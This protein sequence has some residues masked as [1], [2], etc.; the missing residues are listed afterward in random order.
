MAYSTL[1]G[2]AKGLLGT[3]APK[4]IFPNLDLKYI[5]PVNGHDMNAMEEALKQAKKYA[6]PVIVHAIT[7]K[8]KGYEPAVSDEADQFHAVGQIDPDT[9]KSVG[10]SGKQSWTGVFADE[11]VEIANKKSNVIGITAAMLI[12]VGLHKFAKQFP[13][14]KS[15]EDRAKATGVPLR[16]I[17]SCYNRGMAAWRTGHRPGATQQQ[18]GYARAASFAMCGKTHY[19]TDSDLVRSAKSSSASARKWF[20]R[21][22]PSKT[23]A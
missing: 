22:A 23:T 12:P 1:R 9:G 15:L 6:N 7:Q 4:G 13:K 14:A 21:C 10:E 5:G 2:A 19:T 16:L 8:G 20:T 18:W 17:R 11:M 3:F